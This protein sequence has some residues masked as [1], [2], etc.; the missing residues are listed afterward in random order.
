MEAFNSDEN[1]IATI[2]GHLG[3]VNKSVKAGDELW[4]LAGSSIPFLLPNIGNGHYYFISE[5]YVHGIMHGRTL[6]EQE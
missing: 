3:T 1:L 6:A 2:E 4:M 5:A